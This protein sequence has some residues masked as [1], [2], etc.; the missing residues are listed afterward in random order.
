MSKGKSNPIATLNDRRQTTRG[1]SRRRTP[2]WRVNRN[3]QIH[4]SQPNQSADRKQPLIL[5]GYTQDLSATGL[6]I[7]LPALDCNIHDLLEGAGSLEV[8]LST[9]P[10]QVRVKATPVHCET[11]APGLIDKSAT[12]GMLI[13]EQDSNY[14]NYIEYLREFD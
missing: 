3:V 12:I 5:M 9:T 2:R 7:Y 11:I 10:R 1:Q 8:V 6:S 13:D 14:P 4:V